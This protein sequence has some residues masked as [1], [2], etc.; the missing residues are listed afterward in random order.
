MAVKP[1]CWKTSWS[2]EEEGDDVEGDVAVAPVQEN[3]N[4]GEVIATDVKPRMG[5]KT[6]WASDLILRPSN[7]RD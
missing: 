2:E 6:Y 1:T 4:G 5:P 7:S 3:T